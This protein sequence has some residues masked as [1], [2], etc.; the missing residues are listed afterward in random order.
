[1]AAR[2]RAHRGRYNIIIAPKTNKR[3]S[4]RAGER[5]SYGL[6]R[7]HE[8]A[9]MQIVLENH[10]D[11]SL[12]AERARV[13]ARAD[14]LAASVRKCAPGRAPLDKPIDPSTARA[15]ACVSKSLTAPPKAVLSLAH[16]DFECF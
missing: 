7:A 11:L 2:T 13:R 10:L 16:V 1:M 9:H 4:E 5:T 8:G 15:R 12:A 6:T 14:R 3:A